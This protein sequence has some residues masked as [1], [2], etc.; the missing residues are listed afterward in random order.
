M[1]ES[2]CDVMRKNRLL[3]RS[4]HRGCKEMD[5]ILGRF[6]L[7]HLHSLNEHQMAEYEKIVDLDDVLLYS[8][9]VGTASVPAH[10][11][12]ELINM[13]ADCVGKPAS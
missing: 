3:Y 11:D 2:G 5:I 4:T 6:A 1:T 9:V 10:I 12:S 13:I 8:C 7:R